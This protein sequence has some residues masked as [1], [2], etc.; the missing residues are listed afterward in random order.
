MPAHGGKEITLRH[1]ATHTSGLPAIPDNLDPRRADNPYADYTVEQLYAFLSSYPLAREPGATYEYSNLGAGLLGHVV[2]LIH[3]STF[4]AVLTSRIAKPLG[5]ASTRITLSAADRARFAEPHDAS[6]AAVPAWDLPVLAGAGAIRS[7]VND[8]LRFLRYNLGLDASPLAAAMKLQRER[9]HDAPPGAAGIGLGW[10]LRDD[11]GHTVWHNG[12]TG[13]FHSWLAFDPDRKIAV[14]VLA[15]SAY[16]TIDELGFQVVRA[17]R[18]ETVS[19]LELKPRV[20]PPFALTA[21][22]LDALAGAYEL[23]PGFTVDVRRDGDHLVAQATGQPP[24]QIFAETATH[25]YVRTIPLEL[26]FHDDALTLHQGGSE[27]T[28]RRKPR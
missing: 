18:G 15:N 4:E 5:M 6:G 21:A 2:A 3:K 13:G 11:G 22:Q 8:L 1:L 19:P 24:F 16:A 10:H 9:R 27:L 26:D 12:Q 7:T 23:R 14:V 28:G 17:L 25:F 20:R